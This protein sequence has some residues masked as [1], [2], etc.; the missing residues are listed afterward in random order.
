MTSSNPTS[1]AT[2]VSVTSRNITITFSENIQAGAKFS[3]IYVKNL[4]TGKL[5]TI[6]SKTIS[7]NTLTITQTYNRLNNNNY[8]VYLPSAAIKDT[9]GNN[10][11][12]AYSYQFQTI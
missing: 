4:S 9:A 11:T 6:T 12:T 7:G 3:E 2:G 1:G 8:Q 5:T 10:L